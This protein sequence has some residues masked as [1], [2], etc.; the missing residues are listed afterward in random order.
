MDHE[1]EARRRA[2]VV[3]GLVVGDVIDLRGGAD[4]RIFRGLYAGSPG[5]KT[6]GILVHGIG[7]HPDHGVIGTLRM[8]LADKGFST[9][10]IQMPVLAAEAPPQAY[11]KLL[12]PAAAS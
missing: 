1:R 2:E 11:A 3:P 9:L 5:A 7:V 10:S 6:A 8:A 12:A 4:G